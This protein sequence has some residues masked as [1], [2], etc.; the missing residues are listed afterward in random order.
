MLGD[1]PFLALPQFHVDH[2]A[3]YGLFAILGLVA[4]AVGVIFTRVLY[5]IEDIC[6]ALWRGPEWLRPAVGGVLLGLLLIALPEMYGVGYPVLGH[7]ILGVY[8]VAFLLLLAVGGWILARR[9]F[10]RRLAR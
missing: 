8:G 6:D 7:A 2:V 3:Q 10:T 1:V 5:Q 4:G 9:V